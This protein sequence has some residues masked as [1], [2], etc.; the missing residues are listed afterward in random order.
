MNAKVQQP[1]TTLP[2]HVSPDQHADLLR[3]AFSHLCDPN[4]WK[5]PIDVIVPYESANVYMDAISFMTATTASATRCQT[6]TG[7]PAFR[8]RAVGYRA[9]PAGP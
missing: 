7:T 4:D 3:T 9:G 2:R 6:A 8:L 5:A 1:Q